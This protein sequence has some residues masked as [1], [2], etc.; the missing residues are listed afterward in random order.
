MEK[1]E[2]TAGNCGVLSCFHFQE[3][4]GN[5]LQRTAACSDLHGLPQEQ[6]W[7]EALN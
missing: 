2:D 3:A 6:S 5:I 1:T 4:A 7:A